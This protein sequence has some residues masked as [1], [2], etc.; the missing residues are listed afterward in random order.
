M[1]ADLLKL[2]WQVLMA[3]GAM[4]LVVGIVAVTWPA[5]TIAA[6]VVLWGI[7]VLLDGIGW[8]VQ[9]AQPAG[10]STRLLFGAIGAV[11]TIVGVLVIFRPSMTAT[12]VT[13]LLGVWLLVRAATELVLALTRTPPAPRALLALS[14][15]VD[16]V[17]GVLF[18]ANPGKAAVGVAVLLGILGIV[19]GLAL[20]GLAFAVRHAASSISDGPLASDPT[21]RA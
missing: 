12:A 16:I 5:E 13:W 3:R 1:N 21:V 11:A 17:L 20:I 8:L 6:L 19:W 14:G 9:A 10:T 2:S 15:L 18:V 7:F 4:A